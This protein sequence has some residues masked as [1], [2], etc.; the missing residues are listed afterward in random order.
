MGI[1]EQ[2]QQEKREGEG[3]TKIHLIEFNTHTH[4]HT[5]SFV[6]LQTISAFAQ[7]KRMKNFENIYFSKIKRARIAKK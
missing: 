3:H 1:G 7:M 5:Q 2:E 6:D 4:T